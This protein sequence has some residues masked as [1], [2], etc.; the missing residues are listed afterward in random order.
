MTAAS[1]THDE[2]EGPGDAVV[3]L[4]EAFSSIPDSRK[5]RGVRFPLAAILALCV[6]AFL[7]GKQNLTQV[8]R[9]ARDHRRLLKALGFRQKK[10]PSV[11]TLSRV[12]GNV[13]PRDLQRAFAAWFAGLVDSARKRQ[14]CGT[15]SVDG[16]ALW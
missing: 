8:M 3:S 11:P 15:V 9:F 6:T 7:C 2:L 10:G 13:K 16:K 4:L 5:A 1:E 14:L 12:L